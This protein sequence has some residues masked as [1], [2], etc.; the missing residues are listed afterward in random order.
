M[1]VI[2]FVVNFIGRSFT[3]IL[4][5]H[6]LGL[7]VPA[8]RVSVATGA[9]ISLY[10]V[11]A[12]ASAIFLGRATKRYR[13]RVLLFGTLAGGALTV[14]PMVFATSAEQMFAL[15]CVLGLVSG[16]ALTLSYT[17]GGLLIPPERRTSAFGVFS[18]AAL[19]GGAVSPAVAG[20][21][22][23]VDLKAIYVVNAALFALLAAG[24][25]VAGSAVKR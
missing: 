1:L 16:G 3:P 15:A 24:V 17:I 20:A 22:A 7:G 18:G 21:L 19:V 11:A 23:H 2:L 8:D 12:A 14:F 4:A 25:I 9:L 5:P 6:L 13:P 10:S